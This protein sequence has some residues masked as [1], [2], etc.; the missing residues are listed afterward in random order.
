MRNSRSTALGVPRP[1]VGAAVLAGLIGWVVPYRG[2]RRA[3]AIVCAPIGV[4][5]VAATLH[6]Y[7]LGGRFSLPT[8][9]V[10]QPR[11]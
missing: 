11:C 7:G 1:L 9:P 6:L 3:V 5:V 4:A 10:P 2:G 8:Q